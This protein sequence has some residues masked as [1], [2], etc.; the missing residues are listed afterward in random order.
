MTSLKVRV[1][2]CRRETTL[3]KSIS[4]NDLLD[5]DDKKRRENEQYI[6][7]FGEKFVIDAISKK[8]SQ[9]LS[10][11]DQLKEIIHSKMNETDNREEQRDYIRGANH[12]IGQFL[13]DG[14]KEVQAAGI[15]LIPLIIQ[16]CTMHYGTQADVNYILEINLPILLKKSAE[17][18]PNLVG[19]LPK[20]VKPNEIL[21]ATVNI[22]TLGTF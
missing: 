11:V 20:Q 5:I 22:G 13:Q 12:F 9:R 21:N 6:S 17:A 7:L 4:L 3:N 8:H 15:E 10:A 16:Y 1:V 14:V 18:V 2:L 19:D